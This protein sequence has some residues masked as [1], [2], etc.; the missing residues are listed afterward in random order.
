MTRVHHVMYR[1]FLSSM[2]VCVEEWGWGGV[3][4]AFPEPVP[5]NVNLAALLVLDE[6][7]R[8]GDR[9]DEEH[10]DEAET[11]EEPHREGL[12]PVRGEADLL[13]K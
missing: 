3:Y 10:R 4:L 6:D 11:N 5:E 13:I 9:H 1:T 7:D 8:N 12:L 2:R